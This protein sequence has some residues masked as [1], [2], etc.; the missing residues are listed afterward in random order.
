METAVQ[1][2]CTDTEIKLEVCLKSGLHIQEEQEKLK[3]C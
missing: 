3:W 1:Y 2:G